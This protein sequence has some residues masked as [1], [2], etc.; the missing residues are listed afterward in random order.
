MMY[1]DGPLRPALCDI[2]VVP[3]PDRATAP[4]W[5]TMA[6]ASNEPNGDLGALK[7]V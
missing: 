1:D 3:S 7:R 4:G 2:P 5:A 6:L